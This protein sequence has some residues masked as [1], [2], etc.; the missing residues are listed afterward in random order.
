MP[1]KKN[2]QSSANPRF[3]A[4]EAVNFGFETAKDNLF[5]FITL[6]IVVI[7]LYAVMGILQGIFTFRLN[8]IL[9]LLVILLRIVV[10]LIIS[11]GLIKISI[12]FVEKKKPQLSDLFYTK[13]LLNFFLVSFVRGCIILIGLVLLIIP[14]IVFAVKLQF[15]EYLVVDKDEGVVEALSKS[16]D[17][18]RGNI[19]KLFFYGI[20]LFLINVLGFIALLVGLFITVPLTMLATTFVYRKLLAQSH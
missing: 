16:W 19:W 1:T 18:T 17:M 10:S 12:E 14:G 13:S 6:F 8:A 7:L 9:A 3:F 5:Y 11:M 20:L 4:R 15:A 2:A